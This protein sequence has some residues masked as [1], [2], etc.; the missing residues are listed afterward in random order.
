MQGPKWD[1]TQP[2]A[3]R[4]DWQDQRDG[5]DTKAQPCRGIGF[6]D[7]ASAL[8]HALLWEEALASLQKGT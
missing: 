4:R 6:A 2:L 8:G 3:A 5:G 7:L 1:L